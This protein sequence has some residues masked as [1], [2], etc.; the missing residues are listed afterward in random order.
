MKD[1][2]LQTYTIA[3]PILLGYIVWLLQEQRKKQ[4]Q[5]AKERDARIAEEYE[6]RDAN[7]EGTMLL[8]R[9]QLI[10][11]HDKYM[12]IGSIPSYAYENFCE[13]YKAYHRL[14]GNGMVTKMKQEIEEL[15]LKKKGATI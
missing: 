10:E 11:Y 8:L 5:D 13:M 9:V 2:L 7:S 4:I 6:K 14:G 15:H 1:I 12:E 3:L